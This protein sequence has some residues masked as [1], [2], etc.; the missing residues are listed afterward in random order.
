MSGPVNI[1]ES[2]YPIVR[3]YTELDL[4]NADSV[5]HYLDFMTEFYKKNQ[6]KNIIIVYDISL[7]KAMDSSSRAKI[8]EWLK[9]KGSLIGGAV[10][11]VCYVQ[12]NILQKIILQGIFAIKKPDWPNKIVNSIEEAIEWGNSILNNK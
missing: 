10:A 5:N 4:L 8:G 6:G 9:E 3:L 1:D 11:G 7:L 12:T 2:R